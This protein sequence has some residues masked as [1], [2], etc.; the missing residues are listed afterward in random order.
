MPPVAISSLCCSGAYR[1]GD[2][3]RAFLPV[4]QKAR[5]WVRSAPPEEVAAAEEEFFPGV[6]RELLASSIGRYQALGCWEG[7]IE[8]P[9]DLYE[10]ALNVF[11]SVG[12]I[13]WRHR[14]EEV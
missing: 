5:E 14:Y 3:L 6:S 12:G 4:Y 11:Q 1:G 9:R 10:Q 2:D 8:I 13:T 7:G